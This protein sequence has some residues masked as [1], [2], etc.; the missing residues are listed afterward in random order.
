MGLAGRLWGPPAPPALLFAHAA[1]VVFVKLGAAE[2]WTLEGRWAAVCA[3]M[4]R[5]GDYLHPYLFGAPYYDKPL[6]SYWLM[7]AASRLLGRLN[8]TALRLPSALAG[9]ASIWLV[10]K[11]G[12]LRFGRTTGLI[13][14][15]VL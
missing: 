12:A 6:V 9:L 10:Y 1:A 13:A 15:F 3:H 14:G 11:L 8:E 5:S 7:I 2:L 4:L